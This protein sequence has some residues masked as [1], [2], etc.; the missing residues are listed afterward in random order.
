MT[1]QERGYA[2]IPN[3]DDEMQTQSLY[4]NRRPVS[5]PGHTDDADSHSRPAPAAHHTLA[6][7]EV[8]DYATSSA[9]EFWDRL[10]G[11]GR[12]WI[13]WGESVKNIVLSS[14]ECHPILRAR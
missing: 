10:R 9:Q 5:P 2:R 14:C 1:D 13:G 12:R 3:L 7:E 4:P 8:Y 11:K 6:Y